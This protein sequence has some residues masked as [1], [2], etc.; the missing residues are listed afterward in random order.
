MNA[1]HLDDPWGDS[2]REI[3]LSLFIPTGQVQSLNCAD[4]LITAGL[5]GSVKE[6]AQADNSSRSNPLLRGPSATITT[7]TTTMA[8]ASRAKTVPTP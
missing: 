8:A 3:A 5:F 7:A 1:E 4:D 2:W 6:E